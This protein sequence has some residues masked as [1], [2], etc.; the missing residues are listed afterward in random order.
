MRVQTFFDAYRKTRDRLETAIYTRLEGKGM[1]GI[2]ID[3]DEPARRYQRYKRLADKI[4]LRFAGTPFCPICG[5]S[6]Q[7]HR[8]TCPRNKPTNKGD[9]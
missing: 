6:Y 9:I 7:Y 2:A 3:R 5:F 8:S 1:F 4:E